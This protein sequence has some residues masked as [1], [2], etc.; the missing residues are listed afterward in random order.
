[1]QTDIRVEL[2]SAPKLLRALRGLV[3]CYFLQNGFAED[4]ADEVVLAA[5]EACANAMR[6]AYGGREDGPITVTLRSN[7]EWLEIELEDEGVPAP[8][9]RLKRKEMTTPSREALSPGGLGVQ[10]MYH[11]FDQ[12][13]FSPGEE[14]GN[15]VTMRLYRPEA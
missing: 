7:D 6:H 12:V 5:D 8:P 2:R 13:T 10:L 9:D 4:R 1:M 15:C 3:R 14:H 11:V